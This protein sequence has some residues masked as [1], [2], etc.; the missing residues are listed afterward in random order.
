[1]ESIVLDEITKNTI[2][3]A[4]CDQ[5]A[6]SVLHDL[7]A[8]QVISDIKKGF[9]DIIDQYL[10]TAQAMM[11]EMGNALD[12][13]DE[14][15][16]GDIMELIKQICIPYRQKYIELA[17]T[18]LIGLSTQMKKV[19]D[20]FNLSIEQPDRYA[21]LILCFKHSMDT[22]VKSRD[23]IKHTIAMIMMVEDTTFEDEVTAY[24]TQMEGSNPEQS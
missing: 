4:A 24:I 18:T 1:M 5:I 19:Q 23:D 10:K 12:S 8:E 13:I 9:R 17:A 16:D 14:T 20:I 11:I 2:K 3:N 6:T 22:F 15:A 21:E 7:H